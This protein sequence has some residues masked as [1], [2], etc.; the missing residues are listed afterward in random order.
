MKHKSF[1]K[2]RWENPARLQEA[3]SNH[4]TQRQQHSALRTLW[5]VLP[6]LISLH[7]PD[8]TTGKGVWRV[9]NSTGSGARLPGPKAQLASP[10]IS[11]EPLGQQPTSLQNVDNNGT[12]LPEML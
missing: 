11:C 4:W 5:V 6:C 7:E 12:F 1:N 3:F 2:M 8:E 10:L 9:V